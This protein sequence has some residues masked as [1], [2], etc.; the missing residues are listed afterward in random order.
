MRNK[1][2]FYVAVAIYSLFSLS[3]TFLFKKE[4]DASF[5]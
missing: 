3:T 4:V 2:G 1:I 5:P